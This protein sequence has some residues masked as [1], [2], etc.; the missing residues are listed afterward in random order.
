MEKTPRFMTMAAK[1]EEGQALMEFIIFIPFLIGLLS[2]MFTVAGAINGSIN[3]QKSARGYF[4]FTI[5]GNSTVPL[6]RTVMNLKSSGMRGMGMFSIGWADEMVSNSPVAPCYK[7]NSLVAGELDDECKEPYDH[8]EQKSR[9][10]KVFTMYGV[11]GNFYYLN[12][13]DGSYRHAVQEGS[14][15]AGCSITNQ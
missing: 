13:R 15:N 2:L 10:I 7:V 8:G 9:F 11:C 1:R 3:Q 6:S 4:Y 12:P 14:T 5:K